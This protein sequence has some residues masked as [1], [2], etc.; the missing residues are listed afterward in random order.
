ML[1]KRG[2]GCF[3]PSCSYLSIYRSIHPSIDPS[4]HLSIYP[5][6]HL[7]IY[8]SIHP[9]IHLSIHTYTLNSFLYSVAMLLSFHCHAPDKGGRRHQ[10]GSPI[11]NLILTKKY[12][13]SQCQQA[14]AA[15]PS[16][17]TVKQTICQKGVCTNDHKISQ[18]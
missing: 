15:V 13:K 10:G 8:R 14:A 18:I 2:E 1:L 3:F 4:I 5:S 9:S 12:L 16:H 6:I 17:E 7:S 11:Y